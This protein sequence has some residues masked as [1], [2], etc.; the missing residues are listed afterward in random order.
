MPINMNTLARLASDVGA[1]MYPMILDQFRQEF[2]LLRKQLEELAVSGDV[3]AL[4]E[5]AHRMKST[6]ATLGLEDL[7]AQAARTESAA[8]AGDAN[9]AR[10]ACVELLSQTETAEMLLRNL[11]QTPP[12]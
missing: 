8:R 10:V 6:S 4:A 9:A 5:C 3:P 1:D 7:S 12:G 11:P 2:G